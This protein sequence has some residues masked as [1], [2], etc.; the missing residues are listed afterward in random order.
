[1]EL[2]ILNRSHAN[3]LK[4]LWYQ[5][6]IHNQLICDIP[7]RNIDVRISWYLCHGLW[8]F[9]KTDSYLSYCWKLCYLV[10]LFQI[11]FLILSV[12]SNSLIILPKEGNINN[13]QHSYHINVN[14]IQT[15]HK[16]WHWSCHGS[17]FVSLIIRD[18]RQ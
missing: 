2:R 10:T 17:L 4:L 3:M 12:F 8:T 9:K 5:K 16:P 6:T 18:N 15:G 11:C 13:A 1:M 7:W 14:N